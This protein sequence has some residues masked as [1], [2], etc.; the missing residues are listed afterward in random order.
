MSRLIEALKKG[1]GEAADLI[2]NSL[3]E[4]QSVAPQAE[5]PEKASEPV[6]VALTVPPPELAQPRQHSLEVRSLPLHLSAISPLLPFDSNQHHGASE[7]YRILRTKI[8]QHSRQPHMIV[9][10]S[11][12]PG[13]GK[14][15]T[16]INLAGALSLKEEANVLL[17]DADFRRSS[18]AGLL[19]LPDTPGLTEVLHG[20]CTLEEGLIHIEQFPNLYVLPGGEHCKNPV[21]LLDSAAWRSLCAKL[22]EFYKY[23][24]VD[25][26]PIA[27]VADYDLIQA[28]CDG[29]IVVF[30]PD[31]TERSLCFKSLSSVPRDKLTGVV[32]NCVE[33]WFLGSDYHYGYAYHY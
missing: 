22:R 10:S 14:S 29:V 12:G 15:V 21:E 32:L 6:A 19:G 28:A 11:A 8:V 9:I 23:I 4:G 3:T 31:H 16:A 25:S 24:I 7:Q 5:P 26:P 30:R 20:T 2:L 13:D 18:I 17:M 33:K 27:A 1:Q